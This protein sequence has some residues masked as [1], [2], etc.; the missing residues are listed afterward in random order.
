MKIV[1]CDF[2]PAWQQVA[3]VDM[4]SG[5]IE[6]RKLVNGDGE[7][8]EFYRQLESPA[9]IGIE[10]CGNSQWFIDL[11]E[12]LGHQVW[13][14]DAAQIRASYV[15]R[16][17]TDRRDAGHILRLLIEGRFPRLWVPSAEQRDLRQLLIHR[18]K[19]V[20]IRTRVK[21]GLQHLA[22]NR[23]LQ[24]KGSLWSAKGRACFE[25]LPLQ[26]WTA[27]RREDLLKLLAEL[28]RHLDELDAAVSGAAEEDPQAR[29]LM[30]QPGVGPITALAFVL[31]IGDVS[32]FRHSKQVSSYLGLIPQEHSSGGKQRLGS[33]SKQG[34]G[35]MR[36][37]LVEAA[38]SVNRLDE[39]FRKQYAARCHHKAK[40]V[41]KVAAARKLAVRLYWML[42]TK[43]GYPEIAHIESSPRVAPGRPR[44]R[45][46]LAFTGLAGRRKP[47]RWIDWALSHPAIGRMSG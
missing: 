4:E 11:V 29:L 19:L 14:G 16:Q 27:R 18:H 5:E 15:R 2:H 6:E 22:L 20:E 35:F 9:L 10:A 8:E 23:G 25:K 41:A 21:N 13:I 12:R 36:M 28:D 7:A 43:V 31:T 39:G 30:T 38:Q 3:W 47:D 34:N 33:I 46:R 32:R 26:G 24:K 40:G 1:G 44:R 42:R 37:L 17:K 45:T